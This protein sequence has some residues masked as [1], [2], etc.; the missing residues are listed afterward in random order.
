MLPGGERVRARTSR[1]GPAA[2]EKM[3]R[4]FG[5]ISRAPWARTRASSCSWRRTPSIPV[6]ANPAEI[7]QSARVPFRSAASASA[8]TASPGT[9]KTARST[10]VGDVGDRRVG[11]HAG[12]GAGLRVDRVGDPGE[13][14]RRG[15]CGR[16]RRRSSRAASRRRRRR[17]SRG[18][19]KG[20]SDA[21]TATWSRSSTAARYVSVGAIARRTSVVPPSSRRETANPA[22]AKTPQ[23]RR[24]VRHHLGDEGRDPGGRGRLGELL[25]QARA[26][27][28]ALQLV[29]DRERDLGA[30]RGRAA[31]RSSRARRPAPPRPSPDSVP[32]SEPRSSQSGSRN[33]STVAG[34]SDGKPWKRR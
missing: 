21:A 24:V 31:G 18:E 23:H 6:S 4:Q 9:Q 30:T 32:I 33:G 13:V 14:R 25:E 28:L 12:D 5:P 19:K 17:P 16:A 29:R 2:A 27:P 22:S 20:A 26:D 1:S 15:C 8:S 10:G 7:T 34:V 3:P 11:P